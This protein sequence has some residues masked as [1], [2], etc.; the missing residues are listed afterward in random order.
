MHRAAPW[1]RHWLNE[2]KP[3]FAAVLG[4]NLLLAA[5]AAVAVTPTTSFDALWMGGPLVT[6]AGERSSSRGGARILTSLGWPEWIA[7]N[8]EE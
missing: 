5:E 7:N 2:M 8:P 3:Q 4:S 1:W 6:L